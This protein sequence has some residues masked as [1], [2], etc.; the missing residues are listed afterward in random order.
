MYHVVYCIEDFVLSSIDS[1]LLIFQLQCSLESI[2]SR[3]TVRLQPLRFSASE[4]GQSLALASAAYVI[5]H[6][7]RS[8]Y[9]KQMATEPPEEETLVGDSELGKSYERSRMTLIRSIIFNP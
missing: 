4:T 1:F 5:S 3:I 8:N 6:Q 7:Q 2:K 9:L